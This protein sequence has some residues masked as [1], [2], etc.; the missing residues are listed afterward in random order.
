MGLLDWNAWRGTFSQ[1]CYR[2]MSDDGGWWRMLSD[3][4][5]W[6]VMMSD[7]ND[8]DEW[9]MMMS[10]VEW[11]WVM[12]SDDKDDRDEW[13]MMMTALLETPCWSWPPSP[14]EG[15][16]VR[17]SEQRTSEQHY[18]LAKINL[19]ETPWIC[20]RCHWLH[21]ATMRMRERERARESEQ[22]TSEQ[23]KPKLLQWRMMR[24]DGGWWCWVMLSDDERW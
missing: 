5:W 22:T 2:M 4:E 6:W 8:K 1:N 9:F 18:W 3:D 15:E 21:D 11:W 13:Y 7:D 17:E 14:W 23:H 20:W 10:D 19:L 24:D 16:R 12:M